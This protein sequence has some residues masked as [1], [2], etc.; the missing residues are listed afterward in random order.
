MVEALSH[1][2]DWDT[3]LFGGGNTVVVSAANAEFTY[4]IS[5]SARCRFGRD[6]DI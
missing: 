4:D 1:A 2:Y 6:L 5:M 3:D